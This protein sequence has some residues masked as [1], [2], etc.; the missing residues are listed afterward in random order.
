MTRPTGLLCAA[1][2]LTAPAAARAQLTVDDDAPRVFSIQER[3]YRLGHEFEIGAG[4]LPL[5]AFYVGGVVGFSY[6]YHFSDFWAWEI[7]SADYSFNVHTKLRENLHDRY[8]LEPDKVAPEI[9][10]FGATSLVVKPLFGK[11]GWLNHDLVF[12]ETFFTLG[13]GPHML[14]SE[15]ATGGGGITEWVP[16]ANVG[17][18][19][20]FWTS[21]TFSVRFAVRDYLIFSE[22]V[23]T[24]SLLL[25]V[26][27]SFNFRSTG[28]HAP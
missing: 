11:L 14:V 10:L 7:V 15:R 20:R 8:G 4:V 26:S 28:T 5:D 2:V 3:R 12:A 18:G 19:F 9:Q 6:T 1:L 21:D 13:A 23:P 27:G 22:W 16:A 25:M 17:I 24:N